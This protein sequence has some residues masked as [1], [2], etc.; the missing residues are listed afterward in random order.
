MDKRLV[1]LSTNLDYLI[2]FGAI[3]DLISGL[4]STSKR[5]GS[6]AKAPSAAATIAAKVRGK[7]IPSSVGT[8]GTHDIP[9]VDVPHPSKLEWGGETGDIQAGRVRSGVQGYLG[10]YN[11][12]RSQANAAQSFAQ[13]A[14]MARRGMSGQLV[15]GGQTGG[16]LGGVSDWWNKQSTGRKLAIGAGGGLAAGYA[17]ST[18]LGRERNREFISWLDGIIEFADPRPR[19][20]L[21]EFQQQGEGGP[22]PNA[23]ATVYKQPGMLAS[24]A[25]GGTLALAGGA[26]GQVGGEFGKQATAKVK[27]LLKKARKK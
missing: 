27:A 24:L 14:A 1:E 18:L 7:N 22:N 19:N 3:E 8:V 20:T 9:T 21:G 26:V 10:Q 13:K 16:A 11:A 4:E 2:E 12:P 15:G 25:K 5:I 23:M 17:G 6:R